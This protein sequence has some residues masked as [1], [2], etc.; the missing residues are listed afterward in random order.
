MFIRYVLNILLL[1]ISDDMW[2]LFNSF[3]GQDLDLVLIV[4]E[5]VNVKPGL[6]VEKEP[7]GDPVAEIGTGEKEKDDFNWDQKIVFVLLRVC[8]IWSN[9]II[10]FFQHYN[11][12][13]TVI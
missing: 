9:F 6:A 7:V 5:P 4:L 2:W 13:V 11:E 10:F 8:G 1:C 12:N 3:V